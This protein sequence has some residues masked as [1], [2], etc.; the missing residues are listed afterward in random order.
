ML[1]T[2]EWEIGLVDVV[3]VVEVFNRGFAVY[4]K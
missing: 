1:R 4:S 3:F 2:A